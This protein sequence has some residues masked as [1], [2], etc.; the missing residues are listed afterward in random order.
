MKLETIEFLQVIQDDM[1]ING[2]HR[3]KARQL[4][5]SNAVLVP[6]VIRDEAVFFCEPYDPYKHP[7]PLKGNEMLLKY[8]ATK[9]EP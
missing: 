5:E 1:T 8:S 4:L 9:Q 3:I 2:S 6:T 7:S